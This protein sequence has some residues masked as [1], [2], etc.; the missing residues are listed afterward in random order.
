MKSIRLPEALRLITRGIVNF[1][2]G[3]PLAVSCEVTHSCTGGCK[4]CDKGGLKKEANLMQPE[5][6]RLYQ[7]ALKPMVVQMSGGEPLL[8]KDITDIARA[9]KKPNSVPYLILVTNGKL[10]TVEKYQALREVGVNQ[11]SI[12]LD[13]P[14][15]LHDDFRGSPGLYAHLESLIPELVSLGNEDIILNTA[16]TRDN[17]PYI[18]DNYRKACQWGVNI[19]YS[20]YTPLR[21]GSME[22]YISSTGELEELRA[23]IAEL[24]RLK[25]R[26][27]R[28]VNPEWTLWGTYQY[29]KNGTIPECKAGVRFLVVTPNGQIQ[30]CSMHKRTYSTRKEMLRAFLPT[31]TCGECY[32]AIRAYLN[33][34]F[35]KLLWDNFSFLVLSKGK[36]EK[37]TC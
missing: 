10:L 1:I 4:H 18:L 24:I 28:V 26:D 23:S 16:I 21:T 36:D 30:P 13:F 19:S 3:K 37:P 12:S 15:S 7:S 5:D 32:V 29:F 2:T 34:S 35:G 33:H 14:N 20:A 8:R 27:G 9:I 11:F 17:L 6:Y 25:S 22:H 31:N